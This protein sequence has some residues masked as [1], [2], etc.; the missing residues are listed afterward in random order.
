MYLKLLAGLTG[1][2]LFIL[3]TV[4]V[5]TAPQTLAFNNQNLQNQIFKHLQLVTC[6]NPFSLKLT[7]HD[8]HI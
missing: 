5:G 4:M 2:Y 3:M 6:D 7:A 1:L 8:R